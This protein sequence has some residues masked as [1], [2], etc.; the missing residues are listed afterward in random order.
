MSSEP[1]EHVPGDWFRNQF[2]LFGLGQEQKMEV[3]ETI[4][5]DMAKKVVKLEAELDE[6]KSVQ[7]KCKT[8]IEQSST[9]READQTDPKYESVKPKLNQNEV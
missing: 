1:I 9:V 3:L 4:I 6:I 2:E 7:H 5:V 8:T